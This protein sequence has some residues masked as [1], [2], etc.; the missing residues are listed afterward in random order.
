MSLQGCDFRTCLITHFGTLEPRAD[1]PP[2]KH[3]MSR[4][5]AGLA[6]MPPCEPRCLWVGFFFLIK[7]VDLS[8]G[9]EG[10]WKYGAGGA[11]GGL[12]RKPRANKYAET[13]MIN[14][15]T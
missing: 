15:T 6:C 1:L 10:V 2:L 12:Q 11:Q 7:Q 4:P 14:Q 8:F 13:F 9:Y 3:F 5:L